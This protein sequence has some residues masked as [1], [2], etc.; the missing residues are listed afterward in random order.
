MPIVIVF[1]PFR[2]VQRNV[3]GFS[4]VANAPTSKKEVRIETWFNVA[5]TQEDDRE[6]N[7][8]LSTPLVSFWNF[9]AHQHHLIFNFR[10]IQRFG[11]FEIEV[12][13]NNILFIFETIDYREINTNIFCSRGGCKW[14][15]QQVANRYQSILSCHTIAPTASP[16]LHATM[17]PSLSGKERTSGTWWAFRGFITNRKQPASSLAQTVSFRHLAPIIMEMQTIRCV[18]A[19]SGEG[20][21]TC[22]GW[23]V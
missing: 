9:P 14:R 15:S 13:C 16:S 19:S 2:W 22:G 3:P 21:Y 17:P 23:A 1:P 4:E 5:D 6:D 7:H 11:L 12:A 8:S 18:W 20:D 10:D